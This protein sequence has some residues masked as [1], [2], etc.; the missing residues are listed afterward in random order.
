MLFERIYM[1]LDIILLSDIKQE[2]KQNILYSHSF[3]EHRPKMMMMMSI[4]ITMGHECEREM[5]WRESV[6]RGGIK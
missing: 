1:E 3:F 2:Q 5:V 6:G 4:I